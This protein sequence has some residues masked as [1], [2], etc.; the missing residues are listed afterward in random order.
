MVCRKS[1]CETVLQ[2]DLFL[3][4]HHGVC[5]FPQHDSTIHS[6]FE[7]DAEITASGSA[8]TNFKQSPA[9]SSRIIPEFVVKSKCSKINP[10]SFFGLRSDGKFDGISNSKP[11]AWEPPSAGRCVQLAGTVVRAQ[12]LS[13]FGTS[14]DDYPSA[15]GADDRKVEETNGSTAVILSSRGGGAGGAQGTW[16]PK[17]LSEE[18]WSQM[19]GVEKIDVGRDSKNHTSQF[20]SYFDPLSRGQ[21]MYKL[22]RY[23]MYNDWSSTVGDFKKFNV[24]QNED[25]KIYAPITKKVLPQ[26][27]IDLLAE[28]SP[29]DCSF[30]GSH[31]SEFV[32]KWLCDANHY[33]ALLRPLQN[34]HRSIFSHCWPQHQLDDLINAGILREV[35]TSESGFEDSRAFVNIFTVPEPNKN[36]LRLIMETRSINEAYRHASTAGVQTKLKLPTLSDVEDLVESAEEIRCIDFKSYY[37]QFLLSPSIRKFFRAVINNQLFE[38]M[39]LPQGACFSCA[40][41]QLTTSAIAK[42]NLIVSPLIYIDNIFFKNDSGVADHFFDNCGFEVGFDAS[43]SSGR[44]L[45]V[46]VDCKEKTVNVT[47]KLRTQ[48]T[49]S[50]LDK[51]CRIVDIFRLFGLI[52]FASRVLH[53]G[54][55]E[56]RRAMMAFAKVCQFF[57]LG[58]VELNTPL[59]ITPF[60]DAV[61]L[62]LLLRDDVKNWPL[63]RIHHLQPVRTV[64]TDA[65]NVGGAYVVVGLNDKL[66]VVAWKWSFDTSQMS[67]NVR[68]L[69][70]IL[71]AVRAFDGLAV[72]VVTD[73]QVAMLALSKG[74]SASAHINS[75]VGKI[76]SCSQ[77]SISWIP[78][79]QNLAD[80]P[81][82]GREI[83]GD[84]LEVFRE[85][86][87]TTPSRL[88]FASGGTSKRF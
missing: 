75:L 51:S 16:S 25:W 71:T 26:T 85:Q 9:S 2:E 81:S 58:F 19:V 77:L 18:E 63:T 15:G 74:W 38:V 82:R 39:V 50:V 87:E 54:M 7:K 73:S 30:D 60:A 17:T 46:V 8:N 70:A 36:R 13:F 21:L 31:P 61:S 42:K 45:G 65:S 35:S 79:E 37:Y 14:S 83:E 72:H 32:K 22:L 41:A 47:D 24:P 59:A 84:A 68:E 10:R 76:L 43:Q 49:S 12:N 1:Q 64:F 4:D 53:K 67:I 69:L 86:G 48:I 33:E 23:P 34:R 62:F 3:V 78:S 11:Q 20:P 57:M 5:S 40:I 66:K 6:A 80:G 88:W 27:V 56:H 52:A 55:W 28:F 29:S 44:I